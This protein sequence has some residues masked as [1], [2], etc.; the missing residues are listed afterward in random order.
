MSIFYSFS[1]YLKG[2]YQRM[3]DLKFN[4]DPPYIEINIHYLDPILKDAWMAYQKFLAILEKSSIFGKALTS[5]YNQ[6]Y[7]DYYERY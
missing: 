7:K 3:L 2:D 1:S 6:Y 4:D 5:Q